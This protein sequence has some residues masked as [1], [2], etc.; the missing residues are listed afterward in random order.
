MGRLEK[1]ADFLP[2]ALGVVA[3]EHPGAQ[4]EDTDHEDSAILGPACGKLLNDFG[5]SAHGG[6][7]DVSIEEVSHPVN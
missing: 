4:F 3:T 5:I 1:G 6:D 2:F 7:A